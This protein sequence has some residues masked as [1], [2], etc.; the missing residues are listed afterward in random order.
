MKKSPGY[1]SEEYGTSST[2]CILFQAK[3]H[4]T[5]NPVAGCVA[6]KPKSTS[7]ANCFILLNK[8]ADVHI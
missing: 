3:N 5:E 8:C 1:K 7:L 6:M 4:P 2:N